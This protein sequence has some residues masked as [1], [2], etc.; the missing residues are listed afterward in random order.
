MFDCTTRLARFKLPAFLLPEV[1]PAGTFRFLSNRFLRLTF[2]FTGPATTAAQFRVDDEG[3]T[4]PDVDEEDTCDGRCE[5][6]TRR[7]GRVSEIGED[8]C[9]DFEVDDGD[10]A[11]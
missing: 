8:A 10:E 7:G 1:S 11:E 6:T 5:A 3:V 4:D 9:D 2:R